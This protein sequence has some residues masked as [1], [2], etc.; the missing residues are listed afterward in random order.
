MTAADPLRPD[1]ARELL[2]RA[3]HATEYWS[4]RIRNELSAVHLDQGRHQDHVNT[5]ILRRIMAADGW[6]GHR[7]VGPEAARAVW[8]IALHADHNPDFQRTAARLMHR[9][10]QA[11]DAT[12]GQWAHLHD[13]ALL[14]SGQFQ[15]FGSQYRPGG[16]RVE[17]CPVREACALDTRRAGVGLPPAAVALA[18]L[19]ERL[20]APDHQA[21]AADDTIVFTALADAA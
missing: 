4:R 21:D 8:L 16:D 6:P 13:R 9:A 14:N 5:N 1:L 20:A 10:V 19:R 17:P 12:V 3:A 15:E 18:A 7:L 11:S 2:A